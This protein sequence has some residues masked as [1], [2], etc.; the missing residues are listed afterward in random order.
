MSPDSTSRS[1]LVTAL[2]TAGWFAFVS[3]LLF[4]FR[5]LNR[6]TRVG[7]QPFGGLWEQRIEV[8]SFI[9]L[10]PNSLILAPAAALAC[11]AAWLAGPTESLQ[12]AVQLRVVRWAAVLQMVIAGLSIVSI[13]VNETGS[14]TESADIAQR[15][16][17]V[18]MSL[19][20]FKVTGAV[21]R[22]SPGGVPAAPDVPD[23]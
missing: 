4:L 5:Q 10:P 6:V 21:E 14:P 15:I 16:S 3:W 13:I 20:I 7:D 22:H 11:T 2:T 23:R 9:V 17:G 19:A 12:L 18:L 1:D 8:L